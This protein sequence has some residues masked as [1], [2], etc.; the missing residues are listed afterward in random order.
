MPYGTYDRTMKHGSLMAA[1]KIIQMVAAT[2]MSRGVGP[3]VM[4]KWKVSR[5]S[6][7]NI[8]PVLCVNGRKRKPW[9]WFADKFGIK[10]L[11]R[12]L[13]DEFVKLFRKTQGEWDLESH[14]GDLDPIRIGGE[15]KVYAAKVDFREGFVY[16]KSARDSKVVYKYKIPDDVSS[17]STEKI[18]DTGA[19]WG[20]LI[21]ALGMLYYLNHCHYCFF[22][23]VNSMLKDEIY[24]SAYL[25]ATPI[26]SKPEECSIDHIVVEEEGIIIYYNS[27]KNWR[28]GPKY[29]DYFYVYLYVA[30]KKDIYIPFQVDLERFLKGA[31]S[32][33][34]GI[35]GY[36][37]SST[38]TAI[39]DFGRKKVVVKADASITE[40]VR[41]FLGK[42]LSIRVSRWYN[43][44]ERRLIFSLRANKSDEV[45]VLGKLKKAAT[46]KRTVDIMRFLGIKDK[47]T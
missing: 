4:G 37:H 16:A 42:E 6:S 5:G 13:G 21:R 43:G 15:A 36:Y 24:F 9:S 40:G 27:H 33:G 7:L 28:S 25:E 3:Y 17:D 32:Q 18:E 34:G 12:F 45:D 23:L 41:V 1:C 2:R 39:L 22:N 19:T 8:E 30:D 10:S 11:F 26:V 31:S 29:A 44:R 20:P 35:D 14:Y 46:E 47:M 38:N